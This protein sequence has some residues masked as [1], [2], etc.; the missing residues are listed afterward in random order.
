MGRH[1]LH[2]HTLLWVVSL[3]PQAYPIVGRQPLHKH[4]LLW[5]VSLTTGIPYCGSLASPQAYP[6][7]GRH[8]FTPNQATQTIQAAQANS[9]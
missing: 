2:W 4:T 1:P 8:S 7:V 5:V 3:P 9:H 6:I